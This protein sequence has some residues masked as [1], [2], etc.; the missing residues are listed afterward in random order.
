MDQ[1]RGI[2]GARGAFT[3]I[4][5]LVVVSIIALLVAILLP[6]LAKARETAKIL[7][8]SNNLHQQ[9]LAIQNY[10]VDH[11]GYIP[12]AA[13]WT[14]GSG[15]FSYSWDDLIDR[16]LGERWS[17][18]DRLAAW[19]PAALANEALRCPS[20]P[21]AE[22]PDNAPSAATRSY[23][24]VRAFDKDA[25]VALGVSATNRGAEVPEQFRIDTDVLAP[26]GTLMV[27]ERSAEQ[28]LPGQ[29]SSLQGGR[30]FAEIDAPEEQLPDYVFTK[31][32]NDATVER[33]FGLTTH[34]NAGDESR[35]NYQFAD[36]HVTYM[37]II[38]TFGTANGI[39][40][41]PAGAWTRRTD[42]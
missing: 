24:M 38:D 26:S 1:E 29:R 35:Y 34:D 23:A 18:A 17:P 31:T 3:L 42:D 37:R 39:H 8:C 20:D 7:T 13:W 22:Q 5:L 25:E 12:Y 33:G 40:D 6:A 36:G 30:Y 21:K 10:T 28:W 27:V 16:Y 15:S 14:I 2:S 32:D 19:A 9:G 11:Q 41:P 4:E